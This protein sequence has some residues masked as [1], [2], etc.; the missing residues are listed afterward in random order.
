M[1]AGA[2]NISTA[3]WMESGIASIIAIPEY[4]RMCDLSV[5]AVTLHRSVAER[6]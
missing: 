4:E 6:R 5:T 3:P 2:A 1:I